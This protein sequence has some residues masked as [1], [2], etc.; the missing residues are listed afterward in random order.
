MDNIDMHNMSKYDYWDSGDAELDFI[1]SKLEEVTSDMILDDDSVSFWETMGFDG[2]HQTYGHYV[3][4]YESELKA[5]IARKQY[6]KIGKL[7]AQYVRD[8]YEEA[9]HKH[10]GEN[11]EE[12]GFYERG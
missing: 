3:G 5:A 12:Y 2:F 7:V 10:I 4:R 6:E 9:A 1:E 8:C 11:L